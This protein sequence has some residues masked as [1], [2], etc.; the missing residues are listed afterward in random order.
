MAE[1]DELFSLEELEGSED[2][3]PEFDKVQIKNPYDQLLE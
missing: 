2:M 3:Q 1:S